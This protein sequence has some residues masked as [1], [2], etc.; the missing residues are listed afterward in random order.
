MATMNQRKHTTSLSKEILKSIRKF[1][2][3]NYFI[4]KAPEEPKISNGC[5]QQV[6]N[7]IEQGRTDEEILDVQKEDLRKLMLTWN[8]R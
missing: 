7:K 5:A 2:S 6:I 4:R 8:W 3:K 1:M